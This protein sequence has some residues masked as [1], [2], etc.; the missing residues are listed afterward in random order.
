MFPAGCLRR[1]YPWLLVGAGLLL[2]R[3]KRRH[4]RARCR[5]MEHRQE[6]MT[7]I[8]REIRD[9]LKEKDKKAGS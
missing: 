5:R 6:E 2:L 1:A 8:L 3:E 9:S 4:W 7:Q